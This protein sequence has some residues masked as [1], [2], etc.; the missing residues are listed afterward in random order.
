MCVNTDTLIRTF[1]VSLTTSSPENPPFQSPGEMN[2]ASFV[3]RRDVDTTVLCIFSCH[4]ATARP[5]R[6]AGHHSAA[7]RWDKAPELPEGTRAP[8]F[9]WEKTPTQNH[10]ES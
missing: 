4:R 9:S 3:R 7:L 1:L 5:A 2:I 8:S 6:L 10:H